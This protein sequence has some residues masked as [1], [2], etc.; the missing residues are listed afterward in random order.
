M[1]FEA[2]L[3]RKTEKFF[4]SSLQDSNDIIKVHS[5]PMIRRLL[6]VSG[7]ESCGSVKMA[8]AQTLSLRN[9]NSDS[10]NDATLLRQLVGSLLHLSNTVRFN[11]AFAVVYFSSSMHRQTQ[12]TWKEGKSIVSFLNKTKE[13]GVAYSGNEG[14][15]VCAVSN[16]D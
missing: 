15:A 2:R 11:I 12:M 3:D 9:E 13:L 5:A 6:Q 14:E 4:R 8:S 1:A 10:S 16:A 7:V